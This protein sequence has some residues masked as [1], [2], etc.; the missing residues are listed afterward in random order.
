MSDVPAGAPGVNDP[1]NVAEVGNPLRDPGRRRCD[2]GL[3]ADW[4]KI[5]QNFFD[6][7]TIKAGLAPRSLPEGA[8]QHVIYR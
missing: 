6:L 4:T 5:Q 3:L 2:L 1:P 7:D 8:I